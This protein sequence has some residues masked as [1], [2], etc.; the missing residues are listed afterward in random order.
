MNQLLSQLI[1]VFIVLIFQL[2]DRSKLSSELYLSL[3]LIIKLFGTKL[4]IQL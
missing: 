3:F 1:Y 4:A 2:K